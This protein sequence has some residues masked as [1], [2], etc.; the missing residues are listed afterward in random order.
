[1]TD[2]NSNRRLIPPA[3]SRDHVQGTDIAPFTLVEYGDYQCPD[4]RDAYRIVQT[5]QQQLGDRLRFVF[6]HF[7]QEEIHPEAL[8]A[9]EAAE[10]AGAQGKFWEMHNILFENQQKLG[11]GFLLEYAIAIGLSSHQFLA[12]MTDDVHV[13]RVRADYTSGV[14]CGVTHTPT[15]FIND[16][17]YNGNWDAATLIAAILS[18]E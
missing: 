4:C 17:R 18:R 12:E 5:L 14:Q 3:G 10:A 8:H 11:N 1:M 16:V 13:E 9:A 2:A 6:R 7:P 15:F